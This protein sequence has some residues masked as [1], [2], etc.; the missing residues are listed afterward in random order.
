M[1]FLVLA[2]LL[3]SA[4]GLSG[5][6]APDPDRPARVIEP[7]VDESPAPRGAAL[8]ERAMLEG[9][10]AA[11][12]AVGLPP[13]TWNETLAAD[14]AR[15]AAVLAETRE[16]KHSAEPRGAVPEGENLFMGSRGAYRYDEMVRLWVDERRS[17]RPGIFPDISTTGRWQDTAHYS[18][19]IARRSTEIG[20][21]VASS[22]SDDYL[23]CR[24]TPPGNVWG[25][26][27]AE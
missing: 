11:R 26:R 21:A 8:L 19:I 6:F 7:R 4:T 2:L 10:N 20:C 17:Y 23:V 13:L 3:T 12:A 9:H 18:Q 16:F 25:H 15:Y 5:C 1:R 22:R 27:A 24:Y 14:A